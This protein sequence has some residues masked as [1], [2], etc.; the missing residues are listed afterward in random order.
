MEQ[1]RRTRPFK[2]GARLLK[3]NPKVRFQSPG[4]TK[5]AAWIQRGQRLRPFG[6]SMSCLPPER[7]GLRWI[8]RGTDPWAIPRAATRG[9]LK[10][11]MQRPDHD[12]P[13]RSQ[14]LSHRYAGRGEPSDRTRS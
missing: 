13:A 7:R 3:V 6:L 14:L 2:I 4:A 1:E 10:V 8:F 5:I 12:Q 11:R 9:R